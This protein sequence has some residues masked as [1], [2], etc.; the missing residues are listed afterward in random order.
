M[1]LLHACAARIVKVGSR[2]I[3]SFGLCSIRLCLQIARHVC[4]RSAACS[5]AGGTHTAAVPAFV[6][7]LPWMC[8]FTLQH[9]KSSHLQSYT[10]Q[11]GQ[12]RV[13]I[14]MDCIATTATVMLVPGHSQPVDTMHSL[15]SCTPSR[16]MHEAVAGRLIMCACARFT[17]T[18][19]KKKFT[20]RG[21][22]SLAIY[23]R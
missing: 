1:W 21:L 3:A 17:L 19:C 13:F 16:H 20:F 8:A 2:L 6:W 22:L 10:E 23:G 12:R 4:S 11:S 14:C 15:W 7:N 5:P 18:C 9:R